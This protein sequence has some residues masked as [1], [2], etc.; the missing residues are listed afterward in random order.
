MNALDKFFS[1]AGRI[2]RAADRRNP[3]SLRES[4]DRLSALFAEELA[5]C[6]GITDDLARETAGF[7][8]GKYG[9][10]LLSPDT[11]EPG[12]EEAASWAGRVLAL[13]CG[14]FGAEMD[15]SPGDWAELQ[16]AV[17]AEADF[18]DVQVLSAIMSVFVERGVL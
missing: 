11:A 17:S 9:P 7:W 8:K 13:F 18:L 15:F 3:A 5:R 4:F 12:R 6:P 2:I 14:G 16:A 1:D 10:V